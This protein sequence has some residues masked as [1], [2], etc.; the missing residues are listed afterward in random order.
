MQHFEQSNSKWVFSVAPEQ[1]LVAT[2]VGQGLNSNGWVF[3]CHSYKP[4]FKPTII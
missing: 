4:R 3:S 1:K 2:V